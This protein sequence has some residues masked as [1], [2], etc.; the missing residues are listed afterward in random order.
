M[1][2]RVKG[3]SGILLSLAAFVVVI[4][5]IKASVEIIVPMLLAI[6]IAVLCSPL[7]LWLRVRKVPVGLAVFVVIFLFVLV[8]LTLGT[9]IAGS[10]QAFYGDLPEYEERLRL[11]AGQLI[12]WLQSMGM[13]V[14]QD[15]ISQYFDPGAAMKMVAKIF[16]GL[17]NVLTNTFL[18]LFTVI[19]IL[20]EASGL[21]DKVKRAFGDQ[22]SALDHFQSLSGSVQQ[23]LTIKTLVSIGTGLVAGIWLAILGVDYAILWALIAFLLNYIPNIGSIIAAVPAMLV[24][25][26][27]LGPGSM[28]LVALGYVLINTIFGNVIEPKFMGRSLGL[29]TLVV[30]VSLIFWGWVLGPVGMLLSIPLTMVVKIALETSEKHKRL[31]I[32]LDH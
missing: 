27:Q 30:F 6:F 11:Q 24:A 19:F 25:L 8:A 28:A 17:G 5:G 26:I 20:L 3:Q 31:A 14:Q 4:A 32:F 22:T 29:S 15:V 10:L 21:P 23:Y 1:E 18:I 13:E 12:L 2:D 16:S 7:M 9:V